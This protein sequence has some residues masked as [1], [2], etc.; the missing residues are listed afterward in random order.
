MASDDD[1]K[2]AEDQRRQEIE[3]IEINSAYDTSG[4]SSDTCATLGAKSSPKSDIS[5]SANGTDT[6]R[7]LTDEYNDRTDRYGFIH[8]TKLPAA[9]TE[10]EL[11]RNNIEKMREKKWLQMLKDWQSYYNGRNFE[12]VIFC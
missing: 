6:V 1:Q 4:A 11:K 5:I 9:L 2:K 8:E 7:S 3:R 12:K 10:I